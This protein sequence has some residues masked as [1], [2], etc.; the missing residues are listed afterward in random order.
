M[1]ELLHDLLHP[2]QSLNASDLILNLNAPPSYKIDG[3][4]RVAKDIILD[5][6]LIHELVYSALNDKQRFEFKRTQE[7]NFSLNMV[8]VGRFRVSAYVQQ[9]CVGMVVRRTQAYIPSFE[10]LFL[11]QYLGEIA[12]SKR[13][14]V[15][16]T[17]ATGS[18]K[19]TTM[20]A[21]VNYRNQNARDHIITIEDPI[22]FIHHSQS[23]IITQREIGSDTQ[24]WEVALKNA[25][26]QAPNVI[27]L[28]EIR[29]QQAMEYAL[30]YS[31]T[32]HLVLATL[33]ANNAN[34]AIE[35]VVS[36]FPA[37]NKARILMDVA[38]NLRAIISQRLIRQQ[39]AGR[40]PAVEIMLGTPR[41]ADIILKDEIFSLKDA[42]KQSKDLQM[43]CFDDCLYDLY[44]KKL[45]SYEE[46][47][48]NAD[49][50]NDLRL[51]IKLNKAESATAINKDTRDLQV[52]SSQ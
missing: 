34:Q 13:G 14:M 33:H 36:F 22:E 18:G 1:H 43:I 45:I 19:S 47:I 10:E 9:G 24:N 42:I 5:E 27:V 44:M 21:M 6:Y 40:I 31:E 39:H 16:I 51:K 50:E 15:F 11:P 8:G 46:A 25:L 29:D 23:S 41:I 26:R 52:L 20:A 37:N 2:M 30:Q 4:L 3:E 32:G 48:K 35:R 17:G 28:G 49:S 12:L 38:L 7:A